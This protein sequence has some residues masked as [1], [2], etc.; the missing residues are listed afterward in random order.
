MSAVSEKRIRDVP[1]GTV[2]G[3]DRQCIK[4]MPLQQLCAQHGVGTGADNQWDDMACAGA[5]VPLG[6]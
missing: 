2:G 1:S 3:R 5:S 4:A 6:L